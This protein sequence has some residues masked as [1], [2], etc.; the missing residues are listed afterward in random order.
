MSLPPISTNAPKFHLKLGGK[1]TLMLSLGL[2]AILTSLISTAITQQ[3]EALSELL[4]TSQQLIHTTTAEQIKFHKLAEHAKAESLAK[5]YE[6]IGAEPIAAID[7]TTLQ[8]LT[9]SG[10]EDPDISFVSF[11]NTDGRVFAISGKKSSVEKNA[12]ITREI[13]ANDRLVGRVLIGFNHL[14]LDQSV[15]STEAAAARNH[16]AM[17]SARSKSLAESQFDL[18]V[19]G[20]ISVLCAVV[21]TYIT[22]RGLGRRLQTMIKVMREFAQ[23]NTRADA[24][25]K[26][27][28]HDELGELGTTFN[29]MADQI[30]TAT[31]R[32]RKNMEE[33]S[34]A[35]DIS[36]RVEELLQVVTRAAQGDLTGEVNPR[37]HDSI[38]CLA[39]GISEMIRR[40]SA[41][42]KQVQESGILVASSTTQIAATAKE[43]E[44]NVTE[45]AASTHEIMATVTEI[46]ATTR[47]LV[48]AMN[49]VTQV[50]ESTALSAS[51]GHEALSNMESTMRQ[52]SEATSS[53]SNKLAVLSEKATNINTVVTT[54][55][56]VADQTNLLSLN[57]AI[58]AEKAGE[59]GRGFAV[60]ATEIRRLAD[61]T[62]VATWDIEQMVKEMQSAVSSGVMGMDKFSDEVGRGVN[63][64]RQVGG[65]LAQI[66]EQVQALTPRFEVVNQ[67]MQ[68]QSKAAS[69]ITESMVQLNDTAQLSAASLR[70][71]NGSVQ[72]LKDAAQ[73]LQSGVSQFKLRNT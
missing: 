25:F 53:I 52:M 32:D 67:G 45:Q 51:E 71:S 12:L 57:A 56:K 63:E 62:A 14:R 59:Y 65:R 55:N 19:I 13:R 50:A 41:L 54:I 68:S 43:Q 44:I 16:S 39:A 37:G 33:L 9:T 30:R 42:V 17:Q 36:D 31:A 3:K 28:S 70:Q 69:Q 6:K 49:Q 15:R 4:D 24:R 38:E 46:S 58:E 18:M 29:E 22:A 11:E 64:V 10:V 61:Q 73:K 66:I 60:V 5:L 2:A 27:P 23:D 26:T 48:A 72:Q 21:I 7:I 40:L 34:R 1:F 20:V 35:A 8:S 47:E